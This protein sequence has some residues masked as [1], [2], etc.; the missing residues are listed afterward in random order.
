MGVY[1]R[2]LHR[3]SMGTARSMVASGLTV[4]LAAESSAATFKNAPLQK[5]ERSSAARSEQPSGEAKQ[6]CPLQSARGRKD[7]QAVS[8]FAGRYVTEDGGLVLVT[9]NQ[10]V[11][12]LSSGPMTFTLV[13]CLDGSFGTLEREL[14]ISFAPNTVTVSEQ[15]K[16]VA[17]ATRGEPAKTAVQYQ[18]GA[19]PKWLDTNVPGLLSRYKVP[20]AAIAYIAD[21][22][23]LSTH[24]YGERRRGKPA[25]LDT[26]FNIASLSKPITA[27]VLLRLASSKRIDLDAPMHPTWLD[28]D[29]RGDKR[30]ELLT[31]RMAL[32][33]RTGLPNWRAH[34]GNVLSFVVEPGSTFRYSGEGYTYAA[35]YAERRT[36]T[37]FEELAD[38][39][40]FKPIGM[41]DTAYTVQQSWKRRAAY[42][43]D[44]RGQ[45]LPPLLRLD[46]SGACCVHSTVGDYA[47]FVTTVM[48]GP[49]LSEAIKKRR[50]A[51]PQDQ[52]TEMC[53]GDGAALADCPSRIGMGLGW[54]V[55]GYA[56]ETVVTHTGVNEGERATAFFVPE[57]GLGLVI[58]TNGANG[59][60]L[61]RD[62]TAAAYDNPR[63]LRL[64]EAA[65]R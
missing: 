32:L 29:I 9:S 34:T 61:I 42:P 23:V 62:L 5:V 50:F 40:V 53:G 27:E 11:L 54:M 10:G 14:S 57:R 47:R 17:R 24:V 19:F 7:S 41:K 12:K 8:S 37:P 31:P 2:D 28:P 33:H 6:G 38:A 3:L 25:R 46:F 48:N 39:L 52:R 1:L 64:V 63:Y 22:Q 15:G 35:R 49:V 58:L 20:A 26:L 65:A 45:E 21:G 56:G 43:H 60:K 13:P 59:A 55:F 51:L 4:L 44:A 18:G 36:D 30:A 16:V